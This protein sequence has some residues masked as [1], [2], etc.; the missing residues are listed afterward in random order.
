MNLKE[1]YKILEVSDTSSNDDVSRSFKRLA[2]KYHPDKNRDRVD[3][4]TRKMSDL[5]VSY[6]K[7]MEY[8]F[9]EN[10]KEENK[11]P[12]VKTE[13]RRE[14]GTPAKPKPA[15]NTASEKK[16]E[17]KDE[18]ERDILINRFVRER[19]ASKDSLYKYFQYNLYNI[20]R[21]EDPIN[22]GNFNDVVHS[23]RKSYHEIKKLQR[24]TGDPELIDH[25]E[26]FSGMIFNFYRASECVNV[27]DSYNNQDDV[28]AYRL[29]KKGDEALHTAHKEL[30]YER[31][32][33]GNFKKE[34][35]LPFLLKAEDDFRNTLARH[36][37]S[38]W[39]VEAQI[40][41]DYVI[42]LKKYLALFFSE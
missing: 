37:D 36:K 17:F 16:F 11:G 24:L 23:I 8:R 42:S 2:Q 33:R 40:K 14:P 20:I 27:L 31:H 39:A 25:F 9:Q 6:A 22:R 13:K 28:D 1:C 3:W 5:N 34:I 7:I 18:A 4:A 41:F 15:Q 10:S 32:N 30:F 12:R 26:I 19:E 21:R 38:S 35:T 29:Y